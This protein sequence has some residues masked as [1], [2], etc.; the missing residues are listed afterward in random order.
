MGFWAKVEDN[1]VTDIIVADN[2]HINS[3]LVGDPA[4]WLETSFKGQGLVRVNGHEPGNGFL[5]DPEADAFYSDQVFPSWIL[6]KEDWHWHPPVQPPADGGCY[7]WDEENL[8]WIKMQ[9]HFLD[10]AGQTPDQMLGENQE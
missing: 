3:G 7:E 9:N 8:C 6:S 10:C 2:E 5:Y 1:K 4:L